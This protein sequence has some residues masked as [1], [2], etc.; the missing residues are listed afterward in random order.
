M[1]VLNAYNRVFNYRFVAVFVT[2]NVTL[3][4]FIDFSLSHQC[5]EFAPVFTMKWDVIG[6][7]GD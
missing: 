3:V 1:E 4:T 5:H 6:L 2:V 7:M